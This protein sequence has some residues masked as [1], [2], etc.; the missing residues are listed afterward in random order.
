MTQRREGVDAKG[1]SN[2]GVVLFP[3]KIVCSQ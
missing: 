3:E 1:I 2:S